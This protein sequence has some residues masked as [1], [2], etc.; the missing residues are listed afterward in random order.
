MFKFLN[1]VLRLIGTAI[2][3]VV[4][5]VVLN[6]IVLSSAKADL[7]QGGQPGTLQAD[8]IVYYFPDDDWNSEKSHIMEMS[9]PILEDGNIDTVYIFGTSKTVLA[10]E[11]YLEDNHIQVNY[12]TNTNGLSVYEMSYALGKL[13]DVE[14]IVLVDNENRLQ[15][16]LYDIKKFDLEVTGYPVERLKNGDIFEMLYEGTTA[17]KDFCVVNV[18]QYEPGKLK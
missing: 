6:M 2:V 16:A 1:W 8:G 9:L 13:L 15:R 10:A 18:Y 14:S 11:K 12:V 17:V 4:I 3:L 7:Y 5:F